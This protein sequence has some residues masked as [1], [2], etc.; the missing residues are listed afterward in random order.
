MTNNKLIERIL[1]ILLIF[2]SVTATYFS[3]V[4][5]VLVAYNDAAAHLNT[6]RRM[7]DSLTPGVVQIGSVWLPLL[8][9]V[10]LPFVANFFL[11]KTGLA[12]SIV[13]GISFVIAAFYIYKLLFL[14]S[15]KKIAGLAGVIVFVTNVNLLYLQSTSMFE[16]LLMATAMGAVY[17]LTRWA[18]D[19]QVLHLLL[20]AFC[21]MLATLTRYDGWAMFMAS[22]AAVF[23]ISAFRKKGGREGP[24]VLF[25]FLAGFGIFLWL[26]YN[27]L[28][29]ADPLYFQRSEFSAAAQQNVL[30]ARGQLP[31]KHDLGVSFITYSLAMIVNNGVLVVI[32]LLIGLLLYLL[33]MIK[34]AQLWRLMPLLILVPYAF[35]V[36]SLYAGQSVIWMPMLPP[37]FETYFNARYGLLM[38]PAI[39]FFTGYLAVKYRIVGVFVAVIAFVQMYLFFNPSILPIMGEKIGIITLQDTVSSINGQTVAA[40]TYLRQHHKGELIL[41]SSA[42]ADAF[43]YRAGIPLRFFITEGTGKYW[44]ESLDNPEKYAGTIVFFVDESD[45]VGKKVAN[46]A[47]LKEKYTQVYKDSTYQIW[48][49]NNR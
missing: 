39:A 26:L 5:N 9:I 19:R 33:S 8:H 44:K 21:I 24:V 48:Q 37:H 14:V 2:I 42:S 20:G 49:H 29:F 10:Q 35:N 17:F 23:L 47:V 12:G 32:T 4:N 7:I 16:P 36:V 15:G 27:Q 38:L 28:I 1:I 41:V 13:S 31:T 22:S 46:M 30:E 6:S 11:W 25:L 34:Q 18:K 40:S 3:Y 43:I 45:R